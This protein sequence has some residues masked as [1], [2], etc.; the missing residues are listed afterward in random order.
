MPALIEMRI[1]GAAPEKWVILPG[2]CRLPSIFD[3]GF[4]V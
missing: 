2:Y 3:R 4:F 1:A